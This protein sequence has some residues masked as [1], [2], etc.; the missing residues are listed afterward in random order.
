MVTGKIDGRDGEQTDVFE[1]VTHWGL[2]VLAA[3]AG[4]GALLRI[5]SPAAAGFAQGLDQT[6]LLYLAV[7]GSLLLFKQIKTFSV[8]Q[9]KFEMIEKIRERQDKQEER[10]ADIA[11]VLP[12]LLPQN[13]VKH[14][15]N[16]FE[17]ATS[18][19]MGGHP[20]RTE[21]RRL[22]SIGLLSRKS[23][24]HIGEMKDDATFDLGEC[25]ELT[26]LGRAWAIRIQEI[27]GTG[28]L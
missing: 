23:G 25:V 12:L 27:E 20:L 10:L 11:L 24:R 3:L 9:L 18:R 26:D 19:Y 15:K 16:L 1:V 6:T 13:E 2:V 14:V 21:L 28:A 5:F 8:G 17:R 7:A 22:A 4:L